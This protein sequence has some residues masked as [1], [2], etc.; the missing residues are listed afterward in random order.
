M[1]GIKKRLTIS[2]LLFGL[3]GTL[4]AQDYVFQGFAAAEAMNQMHAATRDAMMDGT[5]PQRQQAE[6]PRVSTTYQPSA[7]VS[8]RTRKQFLVFIR[9]TSGEQAA[10]QLDEILRKQDPITLWAGLVRSEGLRP[11]D[12][13]DAM[14]AYWLLN[15]MMA[16]R[17]SGNRTQALAVKAQVQQSMQ[18]SPAVAR[19]DDAGRQEMTEVLVLN[20]L[21]QHAVY[22]DAVRRGDQA[23]IRAL[24][25]AAVKRFRNEMQLDLRRLALTDVG[26][27]PVAP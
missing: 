23:M 7:Q 15:W 27:R 3:S 16:N 21:V 17:G 11:G 9:Q 20:F 5:Q 6:R 26:F 18:G 22:D 12:L 19:L 24:G 1:R 13:A 10:L 14:T 8:E 2:V 4:H 25:D